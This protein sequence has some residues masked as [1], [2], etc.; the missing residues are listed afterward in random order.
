MKYLSL[1]DQ[2]VTSRH[3]GGPIDLD[4][5]MLLA[6]RGRDSV[7]QR[8]LGAAYIDAPVLGKTLG[9]FADPLQYQ[10]NLP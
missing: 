10:F 2:K 6:I 4:G 3:R 5:K 8:F 9:A 7:V 1:R